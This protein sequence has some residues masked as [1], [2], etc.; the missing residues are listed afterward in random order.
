MKVCTCL[1]KNVHKMMFI[2]V[3]AEAITAIT[4]TFLLSFEQS[5]LMV[6]KVVFLSG[7]FVVSVFVV[8]IVAVVDVC[9]DVCVVDENLCIGS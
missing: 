8:F 9:V 4:I 3:A 6:V 7:V 1:D 5:P 2:N